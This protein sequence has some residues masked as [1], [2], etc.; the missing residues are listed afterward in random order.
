MS[1]PK[2]ISISSNYITLGQFLKLVNVVSS[3]GASK[4]YLNIQSILINGNV[5]KRRGRK[6]HSGDHITINQES[7][8][9]Q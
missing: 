5:E 8:T 9:I 1:I 6:L 4:Q 2:V 7:Y 3:G